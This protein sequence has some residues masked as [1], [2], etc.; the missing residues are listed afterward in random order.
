MNHAAILEE[1][2]MEK[3]KSA[4]GVAGMLLKTM[5]GK[6]I[7]RVYLIFQV[8]IDGTFQNLYLRSSGGA[9]LSS[10]ER[11]SF[12]RRYQT[13]KSQRPDIFPL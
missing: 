13:L 2:T 7:F 9:S 8:T 12:T 4:D 6:F 1:D 3:P 11:M 5:D 10:H